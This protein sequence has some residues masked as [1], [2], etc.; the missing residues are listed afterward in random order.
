MP[1]PHSISILV[2]DDQPRNVV[3]LE[4]ALAGLDCRLVKA[5]SG[6]DALK[7]VLAQDF[8]VIVLDVHMPGMDGF[9]TAR[10]IRSRE[11][12][13]STPIIFLTAYDR[14]TPRVME[15]YRLGAVD[16]IYKPF[17]AD[18]LRA[19]VAIFV[20]LFR[21]TAALQQRTAEL[22]RVTADLVGREQQVVALN[23]QLLTRST[24]MERASKHKSD[25][26]SKMSHEIRTPLNAIIGFSEIML[27]HDV[28]EISE[29]QRRTFL[30]HIQHSGHHLL[31][32][33][34]DILDLSKIEAGRMDLSLERIALKEMLVGCVELIRALADPKQINL[35]A[36]CEPDDAVVSVDPP[37]LKQILYNLLSNAVK[38]TAPG[39]EISVRAVVDS[40]EAVISVRD[41]GVGIRPED[42]DLIFEPFR[43]AKAAGSTPHPEGTGLGLPLVRE[44]VELH[45]GRVWVVSTPGVG[46]SF[47]FS[48]PNARSLDR[49]LQQPPAADHENLAQR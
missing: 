23:A 28:T 2:V 11:R 22:T 29:E 16:Y 48:L 39:G 49:V 47:S 3:A 38:F 36:A 35:E 20:E 43:Q 30:D 9:E 41:S 31:G 1:V 37:R 27:D 34:N 42:V 46:S 5:H 14:D 32:L 17:D 24:T 26:L 33:V 44:L 18:I 13:Q 4:A 45:G 21:Q 6:P 10:L 15:G 7:C 25:F 40:T 12:S 8:A 19:K